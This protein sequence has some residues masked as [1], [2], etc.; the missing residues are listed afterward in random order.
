MIKRRRAR[1][2]TELLDTM[3]AVAVLGPRQVGNTTLA[4]EM[5][6]HRPSIYF[7]LESDADRAKLAE[8]ELCIGG[9]EYKLVILDEVH[10]LPGLFHHA[11]ADLQPERK[12]VVYPGD[13]SYPLARP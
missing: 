3:P 11:C 13:E 10:R 1:Q 4:H 6:V 7:D 9:H 5:G 12:I 8:P 2:L